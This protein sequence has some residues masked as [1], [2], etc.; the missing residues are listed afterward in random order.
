MRQD[1][2]AVLDVIEL[3]QDRLNRPLSAFFTPLKPS[4]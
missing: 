1:G 3:A 4:R 2:V